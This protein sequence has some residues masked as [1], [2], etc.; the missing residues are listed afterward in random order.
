MQEQRDIVFEHFGS[1]RAGYRPDDQSFFVC[2]NGSY[3][4]VYGMSFETTLWFGK[5]IAKDKD[6]WKWS[7]KINDDMYIVMLRVA[8]F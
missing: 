1:G 8:H 5:N 7:K 2:Y 4:A 3:I 6:E